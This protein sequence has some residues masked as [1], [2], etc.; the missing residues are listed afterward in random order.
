[1]TAVP[2]VIDLTTGASATYGTEALKVLTGG[3]HVLWAGNAHVDNL[4]KYT[5]GGN[6]RDDI[7]N[8]IGGIIPTNTVSGY[9]IEDVNM[10]GVVQYT[11]SENDR[12][13]ILVNIG[14]LVPTNVRVEQLP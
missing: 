6:D 11:G 10:N 12:D 3:V 5:G 1:L 2:T 7:L 9:R 13:P 14:G 4:I 8:A